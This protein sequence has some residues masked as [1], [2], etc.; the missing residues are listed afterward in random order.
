MFPNAFFLPKFHCKLNPIERVWG[1][2]KVYCR[3]YTNFT[4]QRLKKM[5]PL[6]LESVPVELMQKFFRKVREYEHGYLEG[7]HR[8]VFEKID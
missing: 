5:I 3:A 1:Q 2:S 4:L 8:K 7:F 6:A